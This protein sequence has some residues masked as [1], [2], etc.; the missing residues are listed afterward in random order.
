MRLKTKAKWITTLLLLLNIPLF[1]QEVWL[2][3]NL[4][5]KNDSRFSYSLQPQLRLADSF[6]RYHSMLIEPGVR[7][8]FTDWLNF[9][10]EARWAARNDSPLL[11]GEDDPIQYRWRFSGDWNFK[12][13][14][15]H[16]ASEFKARIRTQYGR[17][18]LA[19]SGAAYVRGLLEWTYSFGK[20]A[21][22]YIATEF[23][24]RTD[25][26]P[27]IDRRRITIGIETRLRKAVSIEYFYR[28][29]KE[30]DEPLNPETEHI[31]G[32]FLSYTRSAK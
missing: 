31:L 3:P 30:L 22:P 16:S 7:Y 24:Y 28:V 10:A 21:E 12:L 2:G 5:W 26:K 20:K 14:P 1:A 8:K 25:E 4:E 11:V 19:E 9:K 18:L 27:G 6:S 15:K 13:E 17:T 23:F 32:F 29:Q